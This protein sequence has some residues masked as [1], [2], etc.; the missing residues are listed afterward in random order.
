MAGIGGGLEDLEITEGGGIE[1]EG[2][3]RAVFAD[4]PEVGW[5]CAEGLGRIVDEGTGGAEGEGSAAPGDGML[6]GTGSLG[7]SEISRDSFSRP[8]SSWIDGPVWTRGS[9]LVGSSKVSGSEADAIVAS[10][11]SG[12][13]PESASPSV[14]S[15]ANHRSTVPIFGGRSSGDSPSSSRRSRASSSEGS[16][17]SA[18]F[19][20]S[21]ASRVRP[22]RMRA[23]PR[24]RCAGPFFGFLR[25]S[26]SISR[27]T[28]SKR[29]SAM[30]ACAR[31]R[32][33]A[34]SS[35]RAS[36]TRRHAR[37]ASWCLRSAMSCLARAMTSGTVDPI[38]PGE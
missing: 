11:S 37:T 28:S 25:S 30:S 26:E 9:S 16:R 12:A 20:A 22:S 6:A 17:V 21:R 32:R 36:R 33:T 18:S 8:G 7:G 4:P 35:G 13:R 34:P 14:F 29:S 15:S 24:S 23:S 2:A 38:R 27:R 31:S 10:P 19:R 1:Q 3:L 5:F